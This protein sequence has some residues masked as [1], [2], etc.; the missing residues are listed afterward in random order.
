AALELDGEP[1]RYAWAVSGEDGGAGRTLFVGDGGWSVALPVLDRTQRLG[2]VL[3]G[4]HHH[5]GEASPEVRSPMPGT[6]VSVAVAPGQAVEEGQPLVSVEAMKMEHQLVAALAGTVQLH[7][8][9]GSLVKADQV[10]ATVVPTE[11]GPATTGPAT[12]SPKET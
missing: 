4:I 11:S 12:T 10:V 8:S 2:R 9:I 1:Y 7:V 3:D 5:A 6:V